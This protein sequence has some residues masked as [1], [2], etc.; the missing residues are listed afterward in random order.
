MHDSLQLFQSISNAEYFQNT[1]VVL[2]F[3]KKDVFEE[4]IPTKPLSICF[5]QYTGA[6]YTEPEIIELSHKI[7]PNFN[8]VQ[9]KTTEKK[10]ST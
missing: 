2:F 1:P 9:Y 5:P 10:K 7:N 4:K 3:N 8:F 6:Q